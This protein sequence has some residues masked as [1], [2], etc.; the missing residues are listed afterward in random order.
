M[1]YLMPLDSMHT[2][3]QPR[4]LFYLFFFRIRA[5]QERD[6]SLVVAPATLLHRY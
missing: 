4:S 2:L 6:C 3:S 1:I 5:L